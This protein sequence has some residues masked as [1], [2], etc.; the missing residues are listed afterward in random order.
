MLFFPILMMGQE[1]DSF[2]LSMTSVQIKMG[3]EA[4]FS[5]G[6]KMYNKC[7]KE[8]GG[9]D[10]WNVWRRVQGKNSVVGIT[11]MMDNWAE[12]DDQNEEAGNKCRHIFPGFI[13]PHIDGYESSMATFMPKISRDEN[14]SNDKVWVTYFR[15]KNSSDFMDVVKTVSGAVKSAE[16]DERGYW[17]S[18][19]GGGTSSP[20]YMVVWGFDKYA[21][22]DKDQEGVWELCEKKH[23]KKKTD[24]LREKFRNSVEE[25]WSYMWDKS[26]ELSYTMEE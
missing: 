23:G 26:E 19:A 1:N 7:Y 15:V 8:N 13:M 25:S 21:D 11:S 9:E 3:H 20:D 16:G 10:S 5:E 4:Q 14:N 22:M 17:Y 2:V 18:F 12:M 24:E 6:M